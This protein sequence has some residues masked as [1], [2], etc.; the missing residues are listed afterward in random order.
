M[1]ID[2]GEMTV[3][4]RLVGWQNSTSA[5]RGRDFSRRSR[6]SANERRAFVME[7]ALLRLVG[8]AFATWHRIVALTPI[9]WIFSD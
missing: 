2:R 6:A 3:V 5:C 9:F 4:M 1:R 8:A 7:R